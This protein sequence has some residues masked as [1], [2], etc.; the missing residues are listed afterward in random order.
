MLEVVEMEV[1]HLE[2]VDQDGGVPR[3]ETP[4]TG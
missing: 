1:V 2:V 3:V 4:L